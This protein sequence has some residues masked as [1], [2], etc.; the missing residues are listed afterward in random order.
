MLLELRRFR[1]LFIFSKYYYL[2]L[3]TPLTSMYNKMTLLEKVKEEVL[4]PFPISAF[5]EVPTLVAVH[6]SIEKV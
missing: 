6:H 2:H 1:N 4:G 5:R 3:T